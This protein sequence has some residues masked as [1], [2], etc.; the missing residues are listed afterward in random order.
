MHRACSAYYKT[1]IEHTRTLNQLK[2][3]TYSN[4]QHLLNPVAMCY[5]ILFISE[6][7]CPTC[8]KP[9]DAI[10]YSYACNQLQPDAESFNR[11]HRGYFRRLADMAIRFLPKNPDSGLMP[12][13]CNMCTYARLPTN[14]KRDMQN[15]L[16]GRLQKNGMSFE[17]M[18]EASEVRHFHEQFLGGSAEDRAEFAEMRDFLTAADATGFAVPRYFEHLAR[19]NPRVIHTAPSTPSTEGSRVKRRKQLLPD[20][21][22]EGMLQPGRGKERISCRARMPAQEDD[23]EEDD[24]GDEGYT[25]Y[26]DEFEIPPDDVLEQQLARDAEE[27][28]E[29][30]EGIESEE[31][32]GHS[33]EE[34]VD[35]QGPDWDY[36][37]P[38]EYPGAQD[39][40]PS[41]D[42][43]ERF[44]TA[45]H[46]VAQ[47]HWEVEEGARRAEWY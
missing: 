24:G 21:L 4:Q 47:K 42:E 32:E 14:Q 29:S 46:G 28:E 27:T 33:D 30:E 11:C 2:F 40:D 38:Y 41:F 9:R 15:S 31:D 20:E 45:T 6:G 25:D 3:H 44:F 7:I 22:Q 5:G 18:F 1:N 23:E 39:P 8:C 13:D 43:V 19:R 10:L 12:I 17:E 34:E 26:D 37:D 35:R 36:H 16:I